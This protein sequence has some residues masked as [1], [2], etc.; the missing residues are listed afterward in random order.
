MNPSSLAYE[1]AAT[2][3]YQGRNVNLATLSTAD[4]ADAID[5]SLQRVRDLS[6]HIEAMADDAYLT[7]HPE[8]T[9]IVEGARGLGLTSAV[10]R[11]TVETC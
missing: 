7:G 11:A 5:L 6:D 10:G 9:E 2:L 3:H 1:I 4:L 8:W